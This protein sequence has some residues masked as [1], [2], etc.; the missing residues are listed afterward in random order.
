MDWRWI[1]QMYTHFLVFVSLLWSNE[2]P[3]HTHTYRFRAKK[4]KIKLKTNYVNVSLVDE[5]KRFRNSIDI[6]AYANSCWILKSFVYFDRK[7]IYYLLP[8][9]LFF[10]T[11]RFQ[12]DWRPNLFNIHTKTSIHLISRDKKDHLNFSMGFVCCCCFFLFSFGLLLFFPSSIYFQYVKRVCS[13][14]NKINLYR[15]EKPEMVTQNFVF[16]F[17]FLN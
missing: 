13:H 9:V 14:A 4:L 1:I 6:Q 5:E 2:S 16:D 15:R 3:T 8:F 10:V 12:F 7:I 17:D 11:D